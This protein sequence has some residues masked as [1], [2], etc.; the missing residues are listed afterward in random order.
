MK[1]STS[2]SKK[3][4]LIA[5]LIV[6]PLGGGPTSP[7]LVA[8]SANAGVLGTL[9]GAYLSSEQLEKDV[10]RVRALTNKEFAINLFVPM[11]DVKLS[12]DQ[13]EAAIEST[14]S[15][16]KELGL[17]NP[18]SVKP[19][20]HPNFDEQFVKV[21]AAKPIAFSFIF[22]LLDSSYLSECRKANILTIGTATSL[23]EGMALEESGVDAVI[24]QGVEAGGHRGIFG[25]DQEDPMIGTM[26]LT[27]LLVRNLKIPVISAGGIAD[28]REVAAALILGAQAVQLGTVFLASKEAATSE[29]YRKALLKEDSKTS[30]LTRAFSGRLA[31]GLPNKF[32]ME[33]EHNKSILPFP[34]QNSFTRDIRGE[35]TK[36]G[37]SEYLSLWAGTGV[38]EIKH[39]PAETIIKRLI[40]ET[41]EAI[42]NPLRN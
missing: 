33:M 10:K 37:K 24:A 29:P 35:S 36:Q 3:L 2:L 41:E 28:G 42:Q 16:R 39:E 1:I 26:A 17:P 32:M 31:R 9:A 8:A 25:A 7:E 15:H 27:R 13:V 20:F 22:G 40:K 14:Q 34:A 23:E 18:T 5:P 12:A 6:A 11:P 4:G 21:L 38:N 30:R 19:P